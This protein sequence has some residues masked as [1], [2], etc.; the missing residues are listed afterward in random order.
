MTDAAKLLDEGRYAEALAP[1]REAHER[2]PQRGSGHRLGF[3]FLQLGDLES[4]ERVLRR[5]VE[6]Y[7]DLIDARNALGVALINQ[8][9]ADEA[10]AVFL[11]AAR[12]APQSAEANNNAGNVLS[13]LGRTQEAIAYLER[14]IA[15]QPGLADAH[16]N[17][18]VIYQSLKRQEEAA[19]SLERA[20][21]LA[22]QAPYTLSYLTGSELALCRWGSVE[23]HIDTLRAQVREGIAAAPFIFVAV[24]PSP[25]EQRRCAETYQRDRMPGAHDPMAQAPYRH[26]RI[27]VAYLSGDFQEH[28]TA[29]LTAGLF[30]RHDRERFEIL[31]ISYGAD[32]GSPMRRR[33]AAGFDRFIDVRRDGDQAVAAM[34]R[35]WEVDIAVDLKG[36]TTDARLGILAHRPAPV[37]ATWLGFPGTSGAPFIDYVVADRVVLPEDERRFYTEQVVYLPDTYQ[38]NDN[39]RHIGAS[40]TR[41]GAGLPKQDFVFCCF[42]NTYKIA[43]QT[44]ALWMRLL[45]FSPR[46][47]LWL[48]D[49]NA[50]ASDNLRREAAARGIDPVRLVFAPRVPH[51]EHLAR[52]RLAD[53]FLDTLPYNAHTTA[54]DALWA[55]LPVL[56][57]AGSTFA[58]RVAESLLRAV[59]LPELVTR[60]HEEYEALAL[61][62]AQAPALAAELRTKLER[63]RTSAPLFDTDRFRRHLESAYAGMQARAQRGEPPASFSV[64]A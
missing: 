35:N 11:E 2:A 32:D 6:A 53:L 31:G 26:Q 37:Q 9:R 60:N 17:L 45:Q 25:E 30:E 12:L 47:V 10:L 24:S 13:D 14:A 34:L 15:A 36:H 22:P 7:P 39:T 1:L 40:P 43:P 21:A 38:V 4:A 33:L 55:G 46:S 52:H 42:N 19:A 61:K 27:R 41:G 49:D 44:F 18:G 62:L 54:S 64:G 20:L 29:Q 3:C 23:A 63:N 16:H 28:A 58:G 57:C 56:T 50:A 48:L 5:E 51:A 59:G 8:G